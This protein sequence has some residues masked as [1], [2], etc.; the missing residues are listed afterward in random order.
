MLSRL[1]QVISGLKRVEPDEF[2]DCVS[3][4]NEVL[5]D[6]ETVPNRHMAIPAMF[7][8]I[9]RYPEADL[10]SPGPLVH[11]IEALGG[12]ES[13]LEASLRRRPAALTCWMVNRILNITHG[14]ESRLRW[15]DILSKVA[16]D[17][18]APDSARA[19]AREFLAHHPR[20]R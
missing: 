15:L 8:V 1:E 10:G 4:L 20:Q 6:F 2:G 16:A 5:E 9:E 3:A 7:A 19:E 13:L 18:S 12:Y 11:E 14:E 17:A